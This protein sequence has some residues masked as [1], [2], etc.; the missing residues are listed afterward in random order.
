MLRSVC[1]V[2]THAQVLTYGEREA[3]P[4][5]KVRRENT[6]LSIVQRSITDSS[7]NLAQNEQGIA[8]QIVRRGTRHDHGTGEM[9]R[10]KDD[11]R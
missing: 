4:R 7:Q 6:M 1:T 11:G 2:G 5:S 10:C 3:F 8:I 9:E